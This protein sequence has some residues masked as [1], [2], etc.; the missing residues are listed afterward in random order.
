MTLEGSSPLTRGKPDRAFARSPHPRLIP[1][2]AGKTYQA[3]AT[4]LQAGA[5]PRSR[6]ENSPSQLSPRLALGSSPLTRGKRNAGIRSVA[7]SRLIPAHAGKTR[8]SGDVEGLAGLIPA[9]AGKTMPPKGPK[10]PSTAHPRSRGENGRRE[11]PAPNFLGSSPL[12]RGKPYN[13]AEG[14]NL[15]G[16]I[17]AHAGKTKAR[18]MPAIIT[19]GS[20]PLT[21][22]KQPL[23]LMRYLIQRLIPAHAGKTRQPAA[24]VF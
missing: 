7:R 4:A 11:V 8:G 17:P 19:D 13:S 18:A 15:A 22:G 5:H 6:G 14:A 24:L 12:T 10:E 1:A 20:S 9:H 23:D 21:R 16:L 3:H 2:H